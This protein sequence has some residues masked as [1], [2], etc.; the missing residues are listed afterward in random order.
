MLLGSNDPLFESLF[1]CTSHRLLLFLT[2]ERDSAPAVY[3][4][5]TVGASHFEK[6]SGYGGLL[7]ASLQLPLSRSGPP[8]SGS[9]S[10]LR[11][12]RAAATAAGRQRQR[13][14]RPGCRTS[15]RRNRPHRASCRTPH[16]ASQRGRW[17]AVARSPPW[18]GPSRWGREALPAQGRA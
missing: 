16:P 10:L 2:A 1:S 15:R 12:P 5:E 9:R 3:L 18:W 14:R 8:A 17:P 13:P 11:S 4:W 6:N 7:L